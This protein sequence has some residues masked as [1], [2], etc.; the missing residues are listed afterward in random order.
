[1]RVKEKLMNSVKH[2]KVIYIV[3]NR[4]CVIILNCVKIFV[5]S[6]D[7]LIVFNSYGGKKFN[8]STK[9]IY[10][11]MKEDDRFKSYK[12]VWAFHRPEDYKDL[13]NKIKTDDFHY[14]LTILKARCWVTN[15]GMQR[16]IDIKGKNTFSFNTWHGTPMKKMGS[17]ANKK[18]T[19]NKIMQS[20][21][22]LLAQSEYEVDKMTEAYDINP[23]RYK[24]IG[25]PR[26]DILAKVNEQMTLRYKEKLGISK[27][28]LVVLYAPTFRDYKLE[29]G[30]NCVLNVPIDYEY[31]E[32][33]FGDNTVFLVRMH[34]EIAKY[35]ELPSNNKWIDCSQYESLN[36][37]MIASDMLISDY[38]SIFF[39]Y[40]IMHKPMYYFTYDYDEYNTKRGLYFDIREWLTGEADSRKLA[41][42]IMGA[43]VEVE[44]EKCKKF[45]EK[46]VEQYGNATS[47]ALDIIYENIS[48]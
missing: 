41:D 37:L 33:K 32:N 1:M 10:E 44:I 5:Q 38:S 27:E 12:L 2:N 7:K 3:F 21:D 35:N 39:D 43:D 45:Q 15:S 40:S 23:N 9:V 19:N 36:D 24:I 6:D 34:Y 48:Q 26:N 17:S 16:G 4:V 28:K 14:F 29:G 47:I 22:V 18:N 20:F 31:W 46:F 42:R 30:S 25:I 11:M 8:D 13:Q